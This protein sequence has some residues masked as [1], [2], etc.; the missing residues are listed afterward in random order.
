[1]TLHTTFSDYLATQPLWVHAVYHWQ[2]AIGAFFGAFILAWT[3]SQTLGTDRRNREHEADAF[4]IALGSE[5]RQLVESALAIVDVLHNRLERISAKGQ[6]K[7]TDICMGPL[8]AMCTTQQPVIYPNGS[9]RIGILG[10]AAAF[11]TVSFFGRLHIVREF[12]ARLESSGED[13]LPL[14]AQQILQITKEYVRA[15]D[16][17]IASIA[18]LEMHSRPSED[19]QLRTR[20]ADSKVKLHALRTSFGVSDD[21]P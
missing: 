11:A 14:F 12:L 7:L 3:V 20:C 10:E 16:A 1:M 5:V 2:D 6:D 13:Q 17:G 21:L 8:I 9:S 19:Q 4:R 15:A 18:S